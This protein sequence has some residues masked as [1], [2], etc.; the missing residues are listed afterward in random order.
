MDECALFIGLEEN[1]EE[2][3]HDDDWNVEVEGVKVNAIVE[4]KERR[5]A[6][7]FTLLEFWWNM[8]I[9]R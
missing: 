7:P 9:F 1:G 2:V 3:V 6:R 8:V 4:L 5:R